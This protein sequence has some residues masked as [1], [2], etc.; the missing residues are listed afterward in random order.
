MEVPVHMTH[1]RSSH[2]SRFIVALLGSTVLLAAVLPSAIAA[3]PSG[4]QRYM[5]VF[6]GGYALDGSYALGKG[7][8][9]VSEE[10][11]ESLD[12][13]YA[14]GRQ[15]ALYALKRVL[16]T[17]PG[18]SYGCI[19]GTS[20]ASPHTTGVAALIISRFGGNDGEGGLKWAPDK[21]SSKLNKT[22]IDIG[23]KGYD[24]CFGNG[25]IDALRAV[26]ND[27]AYKYDATAPFCPEYTE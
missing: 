15:Y 21:V 13:T 23:K 5:V 12:G 27:T 26:R 24:K 7:Y 6:K 14:L 10:A 25:R 22:A 8:A 4:T 20:M 2:R 18:N 9:L 17:L 16:S 11:T 3:P 1:G 19:Q